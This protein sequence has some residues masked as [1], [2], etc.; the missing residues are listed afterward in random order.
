[1]N[2]QRI[3]HRKQ[4][5]CTLPL[6]LISKCYW[7]LQECVTGRI[8][9]AAI[10]SSVETNSFKTFSGWLYGTFIGWIY[11]S[12]RHYLIRKHVKFK[13]FSCGNN[14][15]GW[16]S[17]FCK[18]V[19]FPSNSEF[20][21]HIPLSYTPLQWTN[22]GSIIEK[23]VQMVADGR[24]LYGG[25]PENYLVDWI[26]TGLSVVMKIIKY[27][28]VTLELISEIAT[29]QRQRRFELTYLDIKYQVFPWLISGWIREALK[30]TLKR[31]SSNDFDPF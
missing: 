21:R 19:L 30:E 10:S 5:I 1:M 22:F 4:V 28:S 12:V 16:F 6:P 26:W 29:C 25:V 3:L 17:P 7:T 24:R 2:Q 11:A 14:R 15:C 31:V 13:F 18:A 27:F 9:E 8:L 20:R 23:I